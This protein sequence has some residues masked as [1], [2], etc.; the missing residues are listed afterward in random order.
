MERDPTASAQLKF[1]VPERLRAR[2]EEAAKARGLTLNAEIT[3]RLEMSF[4]LDQRLRELDITSQNAIRAVQAAEARA[5]E[6]RRRANAITD[7]L[8]ERQVP[9]LRMPRADEAA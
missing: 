4:E 8:L 1:R 5:A 7:Y 3:T 9:D 6:D 2:I